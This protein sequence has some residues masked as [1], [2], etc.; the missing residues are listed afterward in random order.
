MGSVEMGECERSKDM[1]SSLADHGIR[2]PVRV[3]FAR[4]RD[5]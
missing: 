1:M 5:H 2:E 4:G 3:S